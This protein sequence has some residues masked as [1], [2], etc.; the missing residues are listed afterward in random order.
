MPLNIEKRNSNKKSLNII[1]T[2]SGRI[3]KDRKL[4]LTEL[5]IF[6]RDLYKSVNAVPTQHNIDPFFTDLPQSRLEF[7]D[8]QPANAG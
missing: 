6:Y 1:K 3:V 4:I 8:R 2:E 7:G 5:Q